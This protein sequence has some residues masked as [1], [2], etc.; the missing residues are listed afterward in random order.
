MLKLQVIGTDW[1]LSIWL[2]AEPYR[3]RWLPDSLE[4][5]KHLYVFIKPHSPDTAKRAVD[6]LIKAGDTLTEFPEK[7]HPWDF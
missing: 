3:L 6:T 2:G 1:R 5:L 4:D 7:G